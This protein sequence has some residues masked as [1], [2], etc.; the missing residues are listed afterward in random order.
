[1][2]HNSTRTSTGHNAVATAGRNAAAHVGRVAA[3]VGWVALAYV[4]VLCVA[5]CSV[6]VEPAGSHDDKPTPTP[7]QTQTVTEP[8]GDIRLQE[9]LLRDLARDGDT[10][11][12]FDENGAESVTRTLNRADTGV[13]FNRFTVQRVLSQEC[14]R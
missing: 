12:L 5:A 6:T 1:M 7:S 8:G 11:Y 4:F 3:A 13:E 9:Q 2:T 10:C 14:D